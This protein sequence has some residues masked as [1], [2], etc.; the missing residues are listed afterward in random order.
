MA[1]R[2][3]PAAALV[4]GAL[5]AP[6]PPACAADPPAATV[7]LNG[8]EEQAEVTAL[9]GDGSAPRA[10]DLLTIGNWPGFSMMR[11]A[12][13]TLRLR[14]DHGRWFEIA[15][16]GKETLVGLAVSD[17]GTISDG[18]LPPED[19]LAIP[20]AQFAA[21]R[22]VA[23][24][25]WGEETGPILRRIDAS[26]CSVN[27]AV[28]RR[29]TMAALPD[30]LRALRIGRFSDDPADLRPLANQTK[31]RR[32]VV[33]GEA[34]RDWSPLAGM[35]ELLH[36]EAEICAVTVATVP[37]LPLLRTY[38]AHYGDEV[39]DISFVARFPALQVL[40]VHSTGVTDL[41][42]IERLRDI[43]EVDATMTQVAKL[44][45][46]K[47]PSLR[48]L[49]ILRHRVPDAELRAFLDAN[50]QC[51]TQH[52]WRA[53]LD[54]RIAG[55]DG[56]RLR[57]GGQCHRNEAEEQVLF[58]TN[59]IDSIREVLASVVIDDAASR[60]HC[61]C[62]GGP[63]VELLRGGTIAASLTIH[64]GQAI[65]W[66]GWPGDGRLTLDSADAF[67]A[68]LTKHGAQVE[69]PRAADAR[70]LAE[71]KARDAAQDALLG[72]E[73]ATAFRACA[74]SAAA[75]A[76]I[77]TWS[78]DPA[79]RAALA[80]RF[81]GIDRPSRDGDDPGAFAD[82]RVKWWLRESAEPT[83]LA[84]AFERLLA[85][86]PHAELAA[87]RFDDLDSDR[88]DRFP[89]EALPRLRL[90]AARVLLAMTSEND[91]KDGVDLLERIVDLPEARE[92]LV[93]LLPPAGDAEHPAAPAD[94]VQMCAA[95]VVVQFCDLAMFPRLQA[96]AAA[97]KDSERWVAVIARGI[98][99]R[100]AAESKP[101]K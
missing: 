82:D 40:D 33:E 20:E 55:V 24:Q 14:T 30:G 86:K 57:T 95:W 79:E 69:S 66:Y 8:T 94:D 75:V 6:P 61:M 52:S 34:V 17:G 71:M 81:A 2:L 37:E 45:A 89:A 49:R 9:E 23:V 47:V 39:T 25:G 100:G 50:P 90:A 74:D 54:A 38:S 19:A 99:K 31:L 36:L 78:T 73:R 29:R 68:W 84:A 87:Q 18:L 21:L 92:I 42:P 98:A 97:S 15:D 16:D 43:R 1:P 70:V 91:R 44:P 12:G 51:A 63:T 96:L 5:L 77:A 13:T 62:C 26:R 72:I 46:G 93:G 3:V 64:H 65:R 67:C 35:R 56:L 83:A 27:I 53:L 85:S 22:G 48:K 80:I 59:E 41:I 88:G 4:L 11:G 10:D 32:L 7:V 76:H 60:G 101:R 58:E 28:G